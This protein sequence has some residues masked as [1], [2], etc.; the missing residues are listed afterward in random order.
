MLKW[1][2]VES[3]HEQ[4]IGACFLCVQKKE[5]KKVKTTVLDFWVVQALLS[6]QVVFQCQKL[7]YMLNLVN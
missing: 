4:D 5:A 2:E 3:F 6:V 7:V 1:P